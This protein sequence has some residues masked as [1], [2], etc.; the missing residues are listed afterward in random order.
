MGK[1]ITFAS[2]KMGW[3][4]KAISQMSSDALYSLLTML[5]LQLN[6][7]K[8]CL[9]MNTTLSFTSLVVMAFVLIGVA[10]FVISMTAITILVHLTELTQQYCGF[11]ICIW[12]GGDADKE[13]VP[14]F[15]S[16]FFTFLCICLTI[17]S[18][19]GYLASVLLILTSSSAAAKGQ[20]GVIVDFFGILAHLFEAVAEG[21]RV[22]E[23]A[24]TQGQP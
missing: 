17:L 14:K 13:L 18:G 1:L 22:R 24:K 5:S 21:A 12:C 2:S 9:T 19:A 3:L 16:P 7:A 20:I 4:S 15:L 8:G 23:D 10:V 6:V 11:S